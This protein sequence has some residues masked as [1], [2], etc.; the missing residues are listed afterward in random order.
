MN[1]Q[2]QFAS[3]LLKMVKHHGKW[4][5]RQNI[6]CYRVYDADLPSHPL[7]IDRYGDWI[8]LAEYKRDVDMDER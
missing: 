1:D 4:G 7:V 6:A 8:H 2:E 3:R 5:R